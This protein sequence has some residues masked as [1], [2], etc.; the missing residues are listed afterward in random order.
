MEITV[1]Q[2][3]LI[4]ISCWLGSVEN[5]QP[6]GVAFSD[7]LSKPIVGGT[8]VGMILGD[9]PTGVTIGAAI[10][11]MYL[12]QVLIGGVATADMAFVSYPSIALA[13]LAGADATVAV[14]LAATVGVLG[15]AVFTGYEILCSV[16][17]QLGDKYIAENNIQKMKM[18]YIVL[19]PMT[20]FVIRFGL[21]FTIVMLGSAYA[22][23]L[24][25]SIPEL[26]LHIASVLG[27]ILPA[28]GISILVT[29]TLKDFKF[30]IYFLIGI[31]CITFLGLNMVATA[32]I[33]SCLAVMYYMFMGNQ[34]GNQ[35]S[36]SE[37]EE[38]ELL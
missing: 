20:S 7:A 34:S 28:V 2:A 29:Y 9:I 12:G 16:F 4:G 36:Q 17:Y 19:P 31:V 5:P 23:D 14:T 8:I 15:A 13:M 21:T 22:A 3:I 25:A 24:L 33:G 32:V 6:L 11:A 37:D 18:A 10:Q 38:D 27:G 35:P 1:I 26:V 30:I